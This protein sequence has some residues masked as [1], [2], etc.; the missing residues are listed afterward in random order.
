MKLKQA[1]AVLSAV[2][3]L[4]VC[5]PAR[6]S[7]EFNGSSSYTIIN[8][9][10]LNGVTTPTFTFDF[11]IKPAE[12]NRFQMVWAKT[13]FWKEWWFG[14]L[15]NGGFGFGQAWPNSYYGVE[16]STNVLKAGQW[17]HIVIVGDGTNCR[18]YIDGAAIQTTGALYGQLSFNAVATGSA[19]GPMVWGLRDNT[20]LPDDGWFKGLLA[21]FRVW[22][23]S[24]SA[25]EVAA[26]H[27]NPPSD[28][29]QGLRHHLPLNEMIGTTFHDVIGGLAGQTFDATW[30]ADVPTVLPSV[31]HRATAAVQ[32]VNGFVVGFTITDPGYGYTNNPLP[33]VRIRDG[34]G[35][36]ATGHAVVNNGVIDQIVVDNAGRN[37]S[38]NAIVKIAPPP[39]SPT[40]KIR[41]LKVALDMEVV[42]GRKYQLE[43][44]TDLQT[45]AKVGT[46][47][48]AEDDII[49]QEF[50]V[51]STGRFFRL[52]EVR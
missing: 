48:V 44:S 32:V 20:T 31:P 36:E 7:L 42:L 6:A 15:E 16:S 18:I 4:G 26:F 17:Q 2:I 51:T 22:D 27:L 12:V 19:R 30:S 39:F 9:S 52:N 25:A 49:Q 5:S 8:A 24:L 50:D 43:A 35:V 29:A 34:S 46:A 14:G 23:R 3:G 11:W 45:W 1:V 47:F 41:V 33:A 21:D 38:T 40:L 13:E 28:T 37:Y 10:F